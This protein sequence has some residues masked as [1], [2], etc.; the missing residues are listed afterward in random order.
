MEYS[1]KSGNPE[2]QRVGCVVVGVFEHRRLSGPAAAVDQISGGYLGSIMRRGDMDGRPGQVF[3][4]H[5]VP[6][7]LSDRVML[8]GCGREREFNASR[9]QQATAAA[10]KALSNN[11]ARDAVSYLTEL[12][13][14]GENLA[15]RIRRAVE[16]T[17]QTLYRYQAP[18]VSTAAQEDTAVRRPLTRLTFAVASRRDLGLAERSLAEGNAAAAGVRLARE[19]GDLPPNVCT[20]AYLADRARQ[21]GEQHDALQ[22]EVLEPADMEAQGMGALLAVARGSRQPA[23]LIVM[24]YQGA[25]ADTAPQVLVGKG[26]TFDAGGISLKP[27]AKMDEM[28]YDMCGAASVFGTVHAVAAM[29]LPINLVGIVPAVE[30]MPD[31]AAT[32]PGDVVESMSGQTIEILNTDAEGR[33]I[34]C[35]ALHYA[36]RFEPASVIDIA[37][38]TG[39][40]VV[41][42][43][44]HASG[45]LGK[46]EALVRR[47]QAA[48]ERSGDRAWPL[49]LWDDYQRQLRSNFADMANVGGREAGTITA[50]CFLSRFT[51][52]LSWAHLD[53]AGVAWTGG[54]RKGATGRPVPLLLEYLREVAAGA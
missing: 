3:I 51:E 54:R 39:A 14:R 7:T 27:A 1:I 33:L 17:E 26:V 18:G 49:P 29:G 10:V 24:R 12:N 4:L 13:V 41:A 30:N 28:K 6:N 50:A 2:K 52:G 47:L 48:G 20:P 40:C 53:I 42:L 38:L 31:G 25:P 11:G 36:R 37:T 44:S 23:R 16:I 5:N 19:L 9:Y 21:L 22:V 32:K 35:D 34:L 15:W 43:G 45:L 8:V 46:D